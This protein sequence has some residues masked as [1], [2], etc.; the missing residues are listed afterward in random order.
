MVTLAVPSLK[1]TTVQAPAPA[2][3][4]SNQPSVPVS[5]ASLMLS[6]S[7]L[8]TG[9]GTQAPAQPTAQP[10]PLLPTSNNTSSLAQ[11]IQNN[12]N[13]NPNTQTQNPMDN[14]NV[15]VTR[16]PGNFNMLPVPPAMTQVITSAAGVGALSKKAF[17]LNEGFFNSTVT[18]NGSG[19]GSITNSYGDGFS[20]KGYN[21]LATANINGSNGIGCYG[22]TL[23]YITTSTGNQNPGALA[24]A[25]PTILVADLVG[26]NQ[27]PRGIP[28]SLG[29]RN[30][31][32]QTG[33][34]TI[35]YQFTLNALCQ[36]SYNIPVDNTVTLTV[37]TD[38]SSL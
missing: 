9:V 35:A 19:P 11:P 7:I 23:E 18:D 12:N 32:Q 33:I 22:F 31:Q 2:P 10:I 16:V 21:Q 34:M 8:K 27:I 5:A 26:N 25:V 14:Q 17:F 24:L 37:I 38:P 30:T 15:G 6:P 3:A 13:P 1:Y 4:V 29:T 20:G 28:I 36:F